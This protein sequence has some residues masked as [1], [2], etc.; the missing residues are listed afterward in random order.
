M[1]IIITG[2]A[3]FVGKYIFNSLKN[4][5]EIYGISRRQSSTTTHSHD[6]TRESISE[7]LDEI[8][9][10]I[11][12]HTAALTSVDYCENHHEETYAANVTGTKNLVQWAHNKKIKFIFISTD[13]VYAGDAETK[14]YDEYSSTNPVNYY[15]ETKLE[16]E[17]IVSELPNSAIL[18]PTFIFGYDIGGMNFL[19]QLLTAKTLKK[20]PYDQISNPTDVEVLVDYVK[21]VIEK[22]LSGIFIATGAETMNKMEFTKKAIKIFNLDEKL[23]Q[24]VSTIE[25]GQNAKR[26]MNNATNSSKIRNLLN[27]SCFTVEDSL[28]KI[29]E[30]NNL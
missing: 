10:D 19:M 7:V 17:K 30:K 11:I 12:I 5:H 4:K 27:Y 15:G 28:K 29:K 3:G 23:F 6:I 1:K 2:S 21:G 9:P 20:I 22:N 16:A 13:A 14:P 24:S 18:R 8:S 25:L 26:P